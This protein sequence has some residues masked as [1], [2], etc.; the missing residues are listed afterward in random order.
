MTAAMRMRPDLCLP[1]LAALLLGVPRPAAAAVLPE[2]RADVLYHY[3]SG[4]GVTI[5][6]PSVLVRKQVG[7]S[8][9]L[10]GNW[11]VDSISGAS[12]DV[13]TTASPYEEERTEYS[14]TIDYLRGSTLLNL[15]F[16]NSDEND[17]KGRTLSLGVSQEMFG[18]MTTVSLGYVRGSDEVGRSNDPDF[19]E[20]LDRRSWRLGVSQVL[21]RNLIAEFAFEAISDDGFLSNPYRQVRY[22]DPTSGRGFSFE[23]ERY[24]ST[25][26]STAA[27]VR[28]RYHLPYRAAVSAEYRYY[29]DD[30]GIDAHT[31]QVG[32][33]HGAVPRWLFDVHYRYYTQGSADFW[34][35]LFPFQNAQNF[36]ARDK[37]L[38]DFRSHTVRLGV[39]YDLFSS[40]IGFAERGSVS[41]IYDFMRFDYREFRD[42]RG[43]LPPGE[44]PFYSFD[45]DVLQLLFS[46]WF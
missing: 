34:S 15:S 37:E 1:L 24:P 3:Y 10:S 2:D 20:D 12:I 21:T 7:Q 35:D 46:V 5:D 32:Y 11:Y 31:V 44:E 42:I 30:W 13:V 29:D 25:R 45:A 36:L 22:L 26:T 39:T 23:P 6:G 14:G 27:G 16:T 33:T 9:S 41:L 18:A 8:V 38:S 19:A 4:G 28:A 43:D 17:Y 40:P